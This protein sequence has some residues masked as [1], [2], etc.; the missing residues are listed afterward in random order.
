MQPL[1]VITLVGCA[2]L[3]TS[4]S[5]LSKDECSLG[6]WNAI[7]FADGA[8]GQNSSRIADHRKACAE[9]GINPDLNLYLAGRERGLDQYC[10]PSN[11]YQ[12]GLRGNSYGGVCHERNE[13]LFLQA[14][15]AGLAVHDAKD[16]VSKAET[17]LRKTQGEIDTAEKAMN[18]ARTRRITSAQDGEAVRA[19]L[20]SLGT[21]LNRLNTE[22]RA[23]ERD[24]ERLKR[25]LTR[26]QDRYRNGQYS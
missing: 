6:D 10:T 24:I 1:K 21:Q 23:L 2:F 14:H 11:G 3:A 20:L 25:E 5:S 15:G 17:E 26:L 12:V 19:E 22:K 13:S 4:C 16:K 18:L 8:T 9:Y 7:G